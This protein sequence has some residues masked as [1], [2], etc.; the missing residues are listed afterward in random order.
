MP[1][2]ARE[3]DRR[4][5]IFAE[6]CRQHGIKATHQRTEIYRELAR[7]DRHPDAETI[8]KRVR[9]RIPAISLDTVYRALR[10]LEEKEVISRVGAQAE[11]TRFDADPR[12]HHHFM[13]TSCGLVR[14][15]YSD[16]LD[17]VSPPAD[18]RSMGAVHS[19]HVEMRGVC[20]AC[21]KSRRAAGPPAIV[22]QS[23]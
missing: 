18:M 9:A 20:K 7:D 8:Y 13:C 21:A 23:D 16:D 4:M 2:D 5:E 11:R 3:I 19:V 1:V 12:R 6:V 10:L 15:F 14:D 17:A 22:A